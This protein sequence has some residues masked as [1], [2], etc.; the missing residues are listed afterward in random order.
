MADANLKDLFEQY[1]AL[2]TKW[3]ALKEEAEEIQ[4]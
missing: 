3:E 1:D 2:N 4:Q